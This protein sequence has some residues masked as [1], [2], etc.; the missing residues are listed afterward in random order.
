MPD[1]APFVHTAE[2]RWVDLDALG[3]L[4]N[5]VYLTLLEEAR[6]AWCTA[7][8]LM[9]AGNFPFLL[10]ETRVRYLEAIREPGPVDVALRLV[11]VGTKSFDMEYAIEREGMRH[12]I[13]WATLVWVDEAQRSAP[14]PE[15]IRA[16][17]GPA[18]G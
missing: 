11:R 2:L 8:G 3:V 10:G 16:L 15:E 5:A 7:H 4:N 9:R 18:E 17:V 1:A 12:A 13:A 6:R 14:V